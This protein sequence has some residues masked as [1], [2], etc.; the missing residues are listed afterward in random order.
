MVNGQ[1]LMGDFTKR[2]GEMEE[3]RW[4]TLVRCIFNGGIQRL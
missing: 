4:G 1:I 3:R 2:E